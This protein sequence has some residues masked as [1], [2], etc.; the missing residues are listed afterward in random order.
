MLGIPFSNETIKQAVSVFG[1]LFNNI[2][3]KRKNGQIVPVAIAYG[4]RDKWLEAHNVMD[5]EKEM[6]EKMLP[7]MSYEVV[8]MNYD[9]QRKLTNKQ[10]ILGANFGQ[11]VIV[12]NV[13]APVPYNLDFSLYIQTKNL[14]D[15]WQIIEQILPFFT[16]AY[17]VRVR[18]YPQDFDSETPIMENEYDIPFVL[19]AVTWADDYT[20]D[21]GDRRVVEWTLEFNTKIWLSGPTSPDLYGKCN[22]N[23]GTVILD[24]R[25][26]Y[27]PVGKDEDLGSLNRNTD[28]GWNVADEIG[29]AYLDSDTA[30]FDSE[31]AVTE[32]IINIIDSDGQIVRVVRNIDNF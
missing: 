14:N 24:S 1:S 22:M 10:Q 6:F 2:V 30:V 17:T 21:Y 7:R 19:N 29:Y 8:A 27:A 5:Q 12:Q 25:V 16:P 18:H 26:A 11:D 23:R 31:P 9:L 13:A 20:G 4:P 3:I 32:N 28:Y 15:G